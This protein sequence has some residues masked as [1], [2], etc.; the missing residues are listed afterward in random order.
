M[1][2]MGAVAASCSPLTT[3]IS[4]SIPGLILQ[5]GVYTTYM[6]CVKSGHALPKFEGGGGAQWGFKVF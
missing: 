3:V 2:S 6:H 5:L 4:G 1:G